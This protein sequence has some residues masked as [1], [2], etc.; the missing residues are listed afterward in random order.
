MRNTFAI[1]AFLLAAVAVGALVGVQ[2]M[3]RE[4]QLHVRV[5]GMVCE[6]CA[7]NVTEALKRVPG[8]QEV[9]MDLEPEKPG[10]I[11]PET[12]LTRPGTATL[13]IKGL[14]TPDEAELRK[15]VKSLAGEQFEVSLQ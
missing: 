2:V 6:G 1:F 12:D 10:P 11:T 13:T 3:A 7:S 8:V 4:R 14:H 5:T 15:A 9:K